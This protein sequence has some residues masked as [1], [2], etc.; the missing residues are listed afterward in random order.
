[1]GL[2]GPSYHGLCRKAREALNSE[3][4]ERA[5]ELYRKAARMD[6]TQPRA[7]FGF[8]MTFAEVSNKFSRDGDTARQQEFGDLGHADVVDQGLLLT[9]RRTQQDI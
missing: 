4:F 8:G 9:S 7:F 6:P 5:F 2:F 3:D 1:M